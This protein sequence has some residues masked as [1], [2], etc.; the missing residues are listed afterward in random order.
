MRLLPVKGRSSNLLLNLLKVNSIVAFVKRDG[1]LNNLVARIL[2]F[3]DFTFKYRHLLPVL[4]KLLL[5]V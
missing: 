5:G 4:L 1:P 3:M 2:S